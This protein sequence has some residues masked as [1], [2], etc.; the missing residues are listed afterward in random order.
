MKK[1]LLPLLL[2][3]IFCHSNSQPPAINKVLIN[4]DFEQPLTVGW[5][6]KN[7]NVSYSD[8]INRATNLDDDEDYELIVEKLSSGQMKLY[9]IVEIANA[10][11]HFSVNAKMSAAEQ[12]TEAE[13]WAAAVIGLLF[14]DKDNAVLG[15][16]KITAKSLHCPWTDTKNL[17]IISVDDYSKW[18]NY[19]FNIND[20]LDNLPGINPKDV[21]KIQIAISAISQGC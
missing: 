6:Q 1:L 17:H 5:K 7:Q 3:S 21:K 11:L 2:F 13:Y 8:E 19:S 18:H 12:N 20:E 4:G 15:E 16:T 10:N 14:L 9:Q